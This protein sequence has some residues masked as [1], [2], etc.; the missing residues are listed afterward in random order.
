MN[1][2]TLSSSRAWR[3][4]LADSLALLTTALFGTTLYFAIDQ[5]TVM[6]SPL[7]LPMITGLLGLTAFT[8]ILTAIFYS[9]ARNDDR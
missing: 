4:S 5:T 3:W 1:I 2:L 6:C 8:A 7:A 9:A